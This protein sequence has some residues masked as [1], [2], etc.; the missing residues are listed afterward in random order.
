MFYRVAG[1]V[2]RK[3]NARIYRQIYMYVYIY[4]I[5]KTLYSLLR[6]CL[7]EKTKKVNNKLLLN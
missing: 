4:I 6:T 7:L 1:T 3:E 2:L 5:H